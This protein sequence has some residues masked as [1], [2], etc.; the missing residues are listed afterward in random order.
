MADEQ[1]FIA[2]HN[3]GK[4]SVNFVGYDRALPRLPGMV[5]LDATADIDGVTKVCPLAQ[6]RGDA[7]GAL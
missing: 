3:K 2:R 7:T 1:A 6:T 4:N 5:L